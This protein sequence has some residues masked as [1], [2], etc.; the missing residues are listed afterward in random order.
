VPAKKMPSPVGDSR[1]NNFS[2]SVKLK[3]F[4][5]VLLSV[6]MIEIQYK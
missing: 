1:S 5:T 3:V 2:S 4:L 6:L